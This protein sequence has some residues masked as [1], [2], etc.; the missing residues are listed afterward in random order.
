MRVLDQMFRAFRT[1]PSAMKTTLGLGSTIAILIWLMAGGYIWG[2][3]AIASGVILTALGID[4]DL[5]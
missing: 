4:K 2:T 3:L 5:G 1:I